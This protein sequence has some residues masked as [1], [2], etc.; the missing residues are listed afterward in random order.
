M[1][2][3]KKLVSAVHVRMR[4]LVHLRVLG[5][6]VLGESCK[7]GGQE[8]RSQALGSCLG[9]YKVVMMMMRVVMIMMMG[10]MTRAMRGTCG[11]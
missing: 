10:M 7:A 3:G 5:L 2:M 1:N 8:D 11:W 9:P 6:K 4:T